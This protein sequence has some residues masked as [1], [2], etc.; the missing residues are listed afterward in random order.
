MIVSLCK[1]VGDWTI[2]G[3]QVTLLCKRRAQLPKV[4]Q[5]I[6][7]QAYSYISDTPDED[8]K[9][10]FI[11]VLREVSEGKIFVELERARMT[12]MLAEME[13]KAG[14]E[15]AAVALLLEC[16]AE[17]IGSMEIKEKAELLLEQIRLCVA[18]KDYIRA[19]IIMSKVTAKV[20]DDAT[21]QDLRLKYYNLCIGFYLHFNRYIDACKAYL[22]LY[23]TP[24]IQEDEKQWRPAL[25]HASLLCILSPY[26]HEM[27]DLLARIS[28]EKKLEKLARLQAILG[29]FSTLE[30]INWP[31][32]AGEHLKTHNL[33]SDMEHGET[34]WSDLRKRAVQHN[35]RVLSTYYTFITYTR[36]AELLNLDTDELEESLS[37]LVSK[38]VLYAKIDRPAGIITF[39]KKQTSD[40]VL[41]AWVN[42]ID[43]LLSLV[44]DT[45]HMINRENMVHGI[46]A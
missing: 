46:K 2:L 19:E 29:Q 23:A 42:D 34:R 10:K 6:I 35:L 44:E 9:K 28:A 16:N 41:N 7:Q 45:C 8:V 32:G 18:T 31:L 11:Q 21:L 43:S 5:T 3:E 20:L 39:Q 40:E 24:V 27:S 12:R 37:A 17:T 25:S 33:F 22:A 36:A 38:G 14:D 26:D 15:A 1:E 13:E 4:V 30:L